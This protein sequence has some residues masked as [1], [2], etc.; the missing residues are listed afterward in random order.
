MNGHMGGSVWQKSD[1]LLS[2]HEQ[3][4]LA[5]VIIYHYTNPAI[6]YQTSFDVVLSLMQMN[7]LDSEVHNANIVR[8]HM[9][10]HKL[11]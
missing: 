6:Y 3:E 4:K 7:N 5:K 10:Y 9:C 1:S 11:I 8:Q 2:I